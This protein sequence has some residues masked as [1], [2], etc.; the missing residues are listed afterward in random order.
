[1]E[2]CTARTSSTGSDTASGAASRDRKPGSDGA[3]GE[4]RGD[5]RG[6]CEGDV[7]G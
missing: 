5:G 7:G 3:G 1:M 6:W 2:T 4:G